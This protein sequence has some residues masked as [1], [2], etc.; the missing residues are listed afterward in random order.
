MLKHAKG[1]KARGGS[2]GAIFVC[3]RRSLKW[4]TVNFEHGEIAMIYVF[5]GNSVI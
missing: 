1:E 5:A 3:M 2:E 4:K